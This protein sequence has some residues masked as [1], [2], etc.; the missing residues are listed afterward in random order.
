MRSVVAIILLGIISAVQIRAAQNPTRQ[1]L[2]DRIKIN[3]ALFAQ[4]DSGRDLRQDAAKK[5][6]D[7]AFAITN[8]EALPIC[9]QCDPNNPEGNPYFEATVK[10]SDLIAVGKVVRNISALS[11]NH[12]VVITDSQFLITDVWKAPPLSAIHAE[13]ESEV[14]VATVGGT[15]FL[16]GHQISS[17][18]TNT[19]SLRTGH[20]YILF[21]KYIPQS[22]SYKYVHLDID[23]YDLTGSEVYPL[24]K[25]ASLPFPAMIANPAKFLAALKVSVIR[26]L[27]SEGE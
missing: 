24:D 17:F 11:K 3:R 21:L 22:H 18:L 6:G 19:Q 13:P 8:D 7:V 4:W 9:P 10:N 1:E 20:T 25:G 14:T 23:G 5:N 15:V 27:H 26:S 16:D 2:I 12:S